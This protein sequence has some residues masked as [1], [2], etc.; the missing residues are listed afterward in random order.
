[1]SLFTQRSFNKEAIKRIKAVRRELKSL[2]E[3]TQSSIKNDAALFRSINDWKGHRYEEFADHMTALIRRENRYIS[4]GY[5]DYL[6]LTAKRIH[7][8][9]QKLAAIERAIEKME[10]KD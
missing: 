10:D 2:E 1:M 3:E 6:S 4:I 5:D 9:E 8:F 7:F